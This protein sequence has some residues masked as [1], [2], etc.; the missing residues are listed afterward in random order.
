MKLKLTRDEAI[1]CAEV[2][3]RYPKWRGHYWL[4][5]SLGPDPYDMNTTSRTTKTEADVHE[6]G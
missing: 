5:H 3:R 4:A 6:Y 1:L 2:A